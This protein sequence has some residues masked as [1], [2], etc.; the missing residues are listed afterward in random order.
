MRRS[1]NKKLNWL[2]KKTGHIVAEISDGA[3]GTSKA[4]GNDNILPHLI[5]N[6]VEIS[7]QQMGK[8]EKQY[9]YF[10]GC[11]NKESK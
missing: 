11:R 4:L 10:L 1:V 3:K 2:Q 5:G 6:L 7:K 9:C 8:N